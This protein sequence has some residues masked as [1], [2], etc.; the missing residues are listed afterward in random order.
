[1]FQRLAPVAAYRENARLLCFPNIW[2]ATRHPSILCQINFTDAHGLPRISRVINPT[3]IHM[4]MNIVENG[5]ETMHATK[6]SLSSG[7]TGFNKFYMSELCQENPT[8]HAN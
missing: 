7:Y 6:K 5:K 3:L 8:K 2:R 4:L 1:M